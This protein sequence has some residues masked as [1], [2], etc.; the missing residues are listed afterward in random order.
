M[1][2][3]IE[4]HALQRCLRY[5]VL[6]VWGRYSAR[7]PMYHFLS[8]KTAG[9]TIFS[10]ETAQA[11]KDIPPP[12]EANANILQTCVAVGSSLQLPWGPTNTVLCLPGASGANSKLRDLL[13]RS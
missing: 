5:L 11:G 10:M 13:L 4:Q 6:W 9:S 1:V 8:D 2:F 7:R 3:S 12:F